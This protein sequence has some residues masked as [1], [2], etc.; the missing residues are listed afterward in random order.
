MPKL[1]A[2]KLSLPRRHLYLVGFSG[3]GKSTL[4]PELAKRLDRAFRD[5]DA[6][7]V[8]KTKKTIAEFFATRGEAAFRKLESETI[9]MLSRDNSPLVIAVGGGALLSA[10]N[11]RTILNSGIVVY[12]RCSRRE[13]YRR[14]VRQTDRPL[15]RGSSRTLMLTMSKLMSVREPGYKLADLTISTTAKTVRAAVAEIANDL[16]RKYGTY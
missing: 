5:T 7:I 11:R 12:L 15:L 14:L 1:S 2:L 8:R 9:L 4:G 10:S 16:K 13:L 6:F 3:S